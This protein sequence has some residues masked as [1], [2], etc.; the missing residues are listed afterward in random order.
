M[1]YANFIPHHVVDMHCPALWIMQVEFR[2][3]WRA[4][5]SLY[6]IRLAYGRQSLYRQQ[7]NTCTLGLCCDGVC[8]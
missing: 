5:E 8:A 4:A 7:I 6:G 1:W 3:K 2:L